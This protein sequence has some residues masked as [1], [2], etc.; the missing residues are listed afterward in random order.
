G[1][2]KV[3]GLAPYGVPKYTSLILDH[4]IDVK[5]DGSYRLNMDYFDYCTGLTMTNER[6]DTLFGGPPRQPSEPLEQRHM[7]LA[8]SVQ[9]V[10]EEI[11]LKMCRSLAR[12]NGR[13]RLCLAGGVA[14]NC[15]ANGKLHREGLF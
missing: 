4:L 5:A 8:A 3:M 13:G 14:L 2:Y 12:E 15:V 7:D 6:F 11:V 9:W 1:E 10:T